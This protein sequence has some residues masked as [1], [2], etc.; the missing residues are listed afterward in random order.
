VVA[1]SEDVERVGLA[2]RTILEPPFEGYREVLTVE[3]PA[4]FDRGSMVIKLIDGKVEVR[5]EYIDCDDRVVSLLS[6]PFSSGRVGVNPATVEP[7]ARIVLSYDDSILDPILEGFIDRKDKR[8]KHAKTIL[9]S[10]VNEHDGIEHFKTLIHPKTKTVEATWYPYKCFFDP[11]E[12]EHAFICKYWHELWAIV[13]ELRVLEDFKRD[14]GYRD[15]AEAVERGIDEK[16]V[17]KFYQTI[18]RILDF[19]FKTKN[20]DLKDVIKILKVPMEMPVI[21]DHWLLSILYDLSDPKNKDS[22]L[23]EII[24]QS[25]YFK[26][27]ETNYDERKEAKRRYLDDIKHDPGERIV[28]SMHEKIVINENKVV[29]TLYCYKP[30]R[31]YSDFI[32]CRVK[33]FIFIQEYLKTAKALGIN[34]IPT[35]IEGTS[36]CK[37]KYQMLGISLSELFNYAINRK[38]D[39]KNLRDL[40][41][42]VYYDPQEHASI[43]VILIAETVRRLVRRGFKDYD[44]FLRWWKA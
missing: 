8:F 7:S 19:F 29:R 18:R 40:I 4:R 13:N 28:Q 22:D 26:I 43:D 21:P 12:N 41:V 17:G 14:E 11:N 24:T 44:E 31:S 6:K 20:L 35:T 42:M 10:L 2:R 23:N 34:V 30:R 39:L 9:K 32:E 27:Y 16:R 36:Y 33:E 5:S 15:I 3:I 37:F 25:S 1:E 38:I